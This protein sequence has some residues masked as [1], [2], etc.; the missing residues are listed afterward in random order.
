ML[1]SIIAILAYVGQVFLGMSQLKNFNQAFQTL[2]QKGKV[3]IGRKVGKVRSGT[4]VLLLVDD[5]AV[6]KEGKIMQG[7]SV[8]SRFKPFNQ[9]NGIVL[10]ELDRQ[11]PLMQQENTLTQEALL[12]AKQLMVSVQDGTYQDNSVSQDSVLTTYMGCK[13]RT[14]KKKVKDVMKD[15]LFS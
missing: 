14:L 9:F 8:L 3:A 7:Y 15:G 6:I 10:S 13:Y 5:A 2:R 1:L 4:I 12:D 11:H